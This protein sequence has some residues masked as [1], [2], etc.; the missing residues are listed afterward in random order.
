MLKRGSDSLAN[1]R[2]REGEKKLGADDGW[3]TQAG[4]PQPRF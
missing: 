3:M 1:G 4:S 2:S